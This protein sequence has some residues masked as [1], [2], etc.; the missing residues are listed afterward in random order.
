MKMVS[1]QSLLPPALVSYLLEGVLPAGKWY[2]LLLRTRPPV[3]EEGEEVG[4][5][6]IAVVVEVGHTADRGPLVTDSVR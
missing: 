2:A 6:D 5:A 1:M 3:G 4:E